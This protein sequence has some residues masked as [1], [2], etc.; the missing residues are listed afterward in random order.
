MLTSMEIGKQSFNR[1][2]FGYSRKEVDLYLEK[3]AQDYEYLYFENSRMKDEVDQARQELQKYKTLEETMH[4][5]L[6][7]AQQSAEIY[8]ANAHK[9]A[10][11]VV[12]ESKKRIARIFSTY[13]EIV[14]RMNLI[15]MEL[16]TQLHTELDLMDKNMAKIE[17]LSS[18]FFSEDMK[19][20]VKG[21]NLLDS[22]P[23]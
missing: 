22:D 5:S 19:E 12:T 21:M 6:I 23:A 2:L 17:E 4:N 16:K 10:E 11:L 3:I 9:E 8:K 14:K 15:A 18:I 20:L 7:L 1:G 13:Q